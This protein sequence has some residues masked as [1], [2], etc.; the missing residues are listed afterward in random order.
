MTLSIAVLAGDYGE[1]SAIAPDSVLVVARVARLIPESVSAL[2]IATRTYDDWLD[3][4]IDGETATR[5]ADN[6]VAAARERGVERVIYLAGLF[7][8]IADVIIEHLAES[9]TI[10][11]TGGACPNIAGPVIFVDALA[12]AQ[13]RAAVPFDAGLLALDS[14]ATTIVT[15]WCGDGV[16]AGSTAVLTAR[17]GLAEPPTPNGDGYVLVPSTR[18]EEAAT[19]ISG[20]R[21]IYARLRRPD[22]C[23]WDRE[24]TEA[25]TLDYISEEVEELRQA[26][27]NNDAPNAAEELG[28]ILGNVL[29][30]AQIAEEHGFFTFEDAVLALSEKLVRRHPHVFG[31][32]RATSPDEVLTIW[33]RVKQL[34]HQSTT[35]GGSTK[36]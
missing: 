25:T 10:T 5:I 29:M 9:A 18:H 34:E 22:G 20:L 21:Q 33:N 32:E 28:D 13:A 30:V 7:S 12:L 4:E 11:T 24:Q 26:L 17:L 1:L 36:A 3:G 35:G 27:T 2:G 19:S 8:G 6:I 14:G 31:D 16:I 15:N 23:P